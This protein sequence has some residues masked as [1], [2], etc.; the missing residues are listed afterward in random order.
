[1]RSSSLEKNIRQQ[2]RFPAVLP[3]RVRGTDRGGKP[4]AEVAHTLDIT[5]TG[6]RLG[7]IR[8]PLKVMDQLIVVYRQRRIA[9]LI[10]WTKLV[11]THE[12]QVGLQAAGA[13]KEVWGLDPPYY[14]TNTPTLVR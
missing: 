10:I 7:A 13:Q 9:F 6:A 3:V 1:M 11:G 4:F 12:Y 8:R 5:T 14:N 2:S